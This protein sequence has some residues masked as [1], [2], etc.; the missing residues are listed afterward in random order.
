MTNKTVT[1]EIDGNM[2][3][4][5]AGLFRE[6]RQRAFEALDNKKQADEDLKE[7]VEAL[8]ETTGIKKGTLT[9]YFK[10][11]HAAKTKALKAE[12]D[13]FEALDDVVKA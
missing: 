5:D 2:H 8:A 11:S 13:V 4:I 10:A 1:I 9:K 7:E 6:Y 3:T 12:S